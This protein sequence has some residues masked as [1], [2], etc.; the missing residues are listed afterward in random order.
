MGGGYPVF[1]IHFGVVAFFRNLLARKELWASRTARRDVTPYI[2][3]TYANQNNLKKNS[4]SSG[5]IQ[6]YA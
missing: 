5:I 1:I 4:K 2:V 6:E 3:T